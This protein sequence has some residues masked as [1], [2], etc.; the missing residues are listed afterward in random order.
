MF[1]GRDG[2]SGLKEPVE[3]HSLDDRTG[4]DGCRLHHLVIDSDPQL[5]VIADRDGAQS[6]EEDPRRS[7]IERSQEEDRAVR[8]G[9]I[10]SDQG[11]HEAR[12]DR[13]VLARSAA[14]R[15][16]PDVVAVPV[17][18]AVLR[19]DPQQHDRFASRLR[20]ATRRR[21]PVRLRLLSAISTPLLE[22]RRRADPHEGGIDR[23]AQRPA[24][25]HIGHRG[26]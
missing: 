23:E 16:Q 4:D 8:R 15:F 9:G 19:I 18:H 21:G 14:Q 26:G 24:D 5:L 3:G 10:R 1:Q 7:R 20:A 6:I 22:L 2:L 12:W 17:E 11:G 25:A 13:Q